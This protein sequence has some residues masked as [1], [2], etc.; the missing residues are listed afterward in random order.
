MYFSFWKKE[1]RI[2]YAQCIYRNRYNIYKYSHES[3]KSEIYRAVM[4]QDIQQ[5]DTF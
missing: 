2:H 3:I 4:L 5:V 1:K